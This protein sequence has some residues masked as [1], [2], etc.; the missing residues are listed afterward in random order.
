MGNIYSKK[1][2]P[3]QS[4][5]TWLLGKILTDHESSKTVTLNQI[6]SKYPNHKIVILSDQICQRDMNHPLNTLNLHF[7]KQHIITS[8]SYG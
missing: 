3:T 1:S 2:S 6:K 8:I 7:N 4:S 5:D